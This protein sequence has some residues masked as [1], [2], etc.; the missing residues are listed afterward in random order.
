MEQKQ[1]RDKNIEINA[2]FRVSQ[3][4]Y[5]ERTANDKREMEIE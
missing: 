2:I 1:R 3:M 4:K 5:I